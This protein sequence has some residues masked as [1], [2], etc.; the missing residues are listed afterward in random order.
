MLS[1]QLTLENVRLR[2]TV[3]HLVK[4]TAF[5]YN[6]VCSCEYQVHTGIV[7][8]YFDTQAALEAAA[9]VV[10]P[11]HNRFPLCYAGGTELKA[12]CTIVGVILDLD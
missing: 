1:P 12:G 11:F 8:A 7:L 9:A 4:R 5:I 6:R 2:Q 3:S 10:E